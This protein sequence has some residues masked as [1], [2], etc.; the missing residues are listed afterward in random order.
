MHWVFFFG[1]HD[2]AWIPD[3]DVKPYQEF[4]EKLNTKKKGA[5]FQ[6]RDAIPPGMQCVI[7]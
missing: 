1:T 7:S 5:S 6:V 3:T 4:R 2:F